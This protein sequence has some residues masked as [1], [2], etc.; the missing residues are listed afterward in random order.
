MSTIAHSAD[1]TPVPIEIRPNIGAPM[2]AGI[3]DEAR[4]DIGQAQ[5]IWLNQE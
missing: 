3:A 1:S 4:L 2:P 5:I